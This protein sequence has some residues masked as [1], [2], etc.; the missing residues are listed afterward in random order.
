[1]EQQKQYA[2]GHF[3]G[4]WTG[5]G[6]AVFFGLGI[7]LSIITENHGLI[8]IGPAIGVS[9]GLAIGSGIEQKY[10]K[11]GLIRPLTE[12]EKKKKQRA[13]IMATALLVLGAI[14][15]LGMFLLN[16]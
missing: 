6:I 14:A 12:E 15:A 7:P 11:Q 4:M 8:G 3:I 16:G 10:K 1:M 5:I 2:E 13:V 9:I